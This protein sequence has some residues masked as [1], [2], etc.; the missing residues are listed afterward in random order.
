MRLNSVDA[1]AMKSRIVHIKK[2]QPLPVQER[3]VE[4]LHP[5][6]LKVIA[7]KYLYDTTNNSA[8][9]QAIDKLRT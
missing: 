2:L 7:D 4:N 5:Y 6:A 8:F 1:E 9:L 3:I